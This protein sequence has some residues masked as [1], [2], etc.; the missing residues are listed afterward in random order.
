MGIRTLYNSLID[1]NMNINKEIL[2]ESKQSIDNLMHKVRDA[3]LIDCDYS[4][5]L[6]W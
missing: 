2:I 5:N 4:N 1:F 6:I 3:Y